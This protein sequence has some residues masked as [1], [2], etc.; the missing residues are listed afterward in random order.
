LK[1]RASHISAHPGLAAVVQEMLPAIEVVGS[2]PASGSEIDIDQVSS[3]VLTGGAAAFSAHQNPRPG[4]E[5]EVHG[6]SLAGPGS[7][8]SAVQNGNFSAWVAE[9]TACIWTSGHG[10]TRPSFTST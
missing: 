5:V 8:A 9:W 3:E 1:K 2:S 10:G 6:G 4:E 7:G